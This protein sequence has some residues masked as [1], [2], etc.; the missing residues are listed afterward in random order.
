[1]TVVDLI[2]VAVVGLSLLIGV[3]RGLIS[4]L[5]SLLS[6]LAAAYLAWRFHPLLMEPLARVI[7][8]PGLRWAAALLLFFLGAVLV[9]ALLSRLLLAL[10]RH[11]PLRGTDRTLG[12][13]FGVARGLLLVT[14]TVILVEATPMQR[15]AWWQDS[16]LVPLAR[17]SA[18]W[19]RVTV[20][21]GLTRFEAQASR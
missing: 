5:L 4:E 18:Q 9:L 20:E 6:W 13:I 7:T 16:G 14:A 10:L 8:S 19:L 15:S 3:W 17:I 2:F 11:S 21:W 1:M 12:G